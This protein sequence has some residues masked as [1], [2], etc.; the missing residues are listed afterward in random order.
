MR[1]QPPRALCR[2]FTNNNEQC[3]G[4]D[5]FFENIKNVYVPRPYSVKSDRNLLPSRLAHAS[6]VKIDVAATYSMTRLSEIDPIERH[7][8]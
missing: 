1:R 5:H 3:A 7:T 8:S 6:D 4:S 2:S